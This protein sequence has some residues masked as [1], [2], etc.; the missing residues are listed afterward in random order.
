MGI[1]NGLTESTE[2]PSKRPDNRKEDQ[3]W[4]FL[5]ARSFV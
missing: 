4:R 5:A 1:P 3:S 2:H